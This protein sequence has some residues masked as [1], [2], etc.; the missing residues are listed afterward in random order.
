MKI[1]LN[2]ELRELASDATLADAVRASGAA[3]DG[4]GVAVALD[5]EV[6]PRAEWD[7]T[8]LAE[9]S[10]VEVL[11][12]IQGGAHEQDMQ[13]DDFVVARSRGIRR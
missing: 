1:D 2:G 4:R 9:G 10:S 8:P 6:V 11:A 3:E 7:L 13:Q 12:A 5:G